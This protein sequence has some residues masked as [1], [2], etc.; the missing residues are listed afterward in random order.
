[1]WPR[2]GGLLIPH[3]RHS[4]L[5]RYRVRPRF[6]TTLRDRRGPIDVHGDGEIPGIEKVA[7][8]RDDHGSDGTH[9]GF[10]VP[11]RNPSNQSPQT[12]H[13]WSVHHTQLASGVL[14]FSAVLRA[15]TR[16]AAHCAI[17]LRM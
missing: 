8:R 7:E 5:Q 13:P 2:I 9:L 15:I 4:A 12:S 17:L 14:H 6:K 10:R 16:S 1:M 3:R 11:E